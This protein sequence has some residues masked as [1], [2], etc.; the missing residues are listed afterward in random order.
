MFLFS[1]FRRDAQKKAYTGAICGLGRDPRT[2]GSAFP[3]HD[4]ELEF[5]THIDVNDIL[6][7]SVGY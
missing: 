3:D 6:Q 5:D 2:G 1:A 7:V 4:M